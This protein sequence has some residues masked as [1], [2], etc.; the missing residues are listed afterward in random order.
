M[1]IARRGFPG[2]LNGYPI[3]R[4]FARRLT[5]SW[6]RRLDDVVDRIKAGELILRDDP[7]SRALRLFQH[8]VGLGVP[9]DLLPQC[10]HF[11]AGT[12]AEPIERASRPFRRGFSC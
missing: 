8:R 3:F 4:D 5:E 6:T 2:R 7:M 12:A 10:R 9:C 1:Q 11:L